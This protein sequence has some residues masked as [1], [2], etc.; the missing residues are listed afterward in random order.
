MDAVLGVRSRSVKVGTLDFNFS[1]SVSET[2]ICSDSLAKR[3][4]GVNDLSFSVV[5]LAEE[6]GKLELKGVELVAQSQD[7]RSAFFDT[8]SEGNIM[9]RLDQR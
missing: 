3:G 7:G 8:R 4:D 2:S 5:S 6:R 1:E 9:I